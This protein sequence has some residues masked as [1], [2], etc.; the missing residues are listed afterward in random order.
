MT[1][2][3]STT[4]E[5]VLP[6]LADSLKKVLQQH[7]STSADVE[8]MLDEHPPFPGP[9]LDAR[10]RRQDRSTHPHR[11]RRRLG[12]RLGRPPDPHTA[13]AP[14]THRSGPSIHGEHPAH[15]GNR[16]LERTLFLSAFAALH[17][18]TS[19]AYYNRKRAEGKKHNAALT[20]LARR[21]CDVL[22]AMLENKTFYRRPT[23]EAA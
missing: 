15:S 5:I 13:I 4:T 12:R 22:H 21:R 16:K 11:D 14:V 6:K 7:R 10:H 8:R 19:R 3:G 18:P 2:P 20:C 17:D 9:D 1:A 23:A